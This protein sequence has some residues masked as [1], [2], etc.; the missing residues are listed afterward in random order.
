M[1]VHLCT[2]RNKDDDNIYLYAHNCTGANFRR[3]IKYHKEM[4]GN[5]YGPIITME[6]PEPKPR[7]K[8]AARTNT[9]MK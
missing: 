6:V 3:T 1:K 2:Y 4:F 5:V 7:K 9:K 8:C